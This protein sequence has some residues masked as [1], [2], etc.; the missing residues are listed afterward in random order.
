MIK[1]RV[2][3]IVEMLGAEVSAVHGDAQ[4]M[5]AGVST[6]TRTLQVGQL[7]VPLVGER[8]DGHGYVEQALASGASAM[9]CQADREQEWS[10][11]D[12]PVIVVRDTLSALQQLA[13]AYRLQLGLKVVAVTGSNGK[14]TT[15]DMISELLN[16]TFRVHKTPG[17]LN[18]H[19][20]LPL[21][22]LQADERAQVLVAE[23]GMS[24]LGEIAQLSALA[25]PDIA[26]ITMIGESHLEQ[27]GSRSAIA[28]AKMEI[29]HSLAPGGLFIYNGD[30]PLLRE[31]LAVVPAGVRTMT[32]GLSETADYYATN[33]EVDEW[34]TG[35]AV[36]GRSAPH[37]HMPLL[38]RHNITNTLAAIAVA[39][40]MGVHP[41][42]LAEPLARLKITA[43]R[44]EKW[45]APNGALILNDAYNA[46]PSSMMAALHLL[47]ELQ[48]AENKVAVL[49]DMLEL[50]AQTAEFH[51]QIGAA[52]VVRE[53]THIYTFGE[54]A[55]LL[56]EEARRH[57]PSL[58]V[59]SNLN[60]QQIAAEIA[61][62]ADHRTA[63]LVKASRGM[64][65]E[66][67]V[68]SL[69]QSLSE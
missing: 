57:A 45:V 64:K 49:G 10:T 27:L 24:G 53:L 12:V 11:G 7:F 19:I 30:E 65:L 15:K 40:Q 39:E 67:V 58:I 56:A 33:I 13:S 32:F 25:K 35:F 34:G 60:K 36:N 61:S 44:N 69:R 54:Q 8:F 37:Y 43:M 21:T 68:H 6:D 50:G 16:C 51:R 66:E 9:L 52:E 3:E 38:G 20:G 22:I 5:M 47:A 1:R 4:V 46:S 59:K 62:F 23:M 29:V 2:S 55:A 26:V 18:N 63:V 41:R 17:N 31:R 42:A 14:T 48:S 28:D